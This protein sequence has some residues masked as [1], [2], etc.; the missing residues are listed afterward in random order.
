MTTDTAVAPIHK[1]I[2]VAC[3]V[4]RA[5]ETFTDGI[6]DWWPLPSHSVGGARAESV[7]F[8]SGAEGRLVERLSD[9][10]DLVWGY[11][12]AWEPPKRLVI[13]WHP[14][15]DS[16]RTRIHEATEVEV[17]FTP[18]ADGTRVD[19]VHRGWERLKERAAE[20]RERYRTG[21]D[22]VLARYVEA[23]AT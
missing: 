16:S 23:T 13:S 2:T 4:E 11:V 3:P 17:T 15:E 6:A 14:G 20:A 21:W 12:L 10:T 5:F 7:R 8:D 18:K 22:P 9:G 19:L 1:T